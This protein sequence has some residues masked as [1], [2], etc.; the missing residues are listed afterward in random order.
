MSQYQDSPMGPAV[1]P[2]AGHS[3]AAPQEAP[4][5]P[6]L[7]VGI[8]A[9]AG[10]LAA[11]EQLF[12]ALP[13]DCGL[14]IVLAALPP[15][16]TPVQLVELLGRCTP[17]P[18]VLAEE[19]MRL[20]PDRVHVLAAGD[21]LVVNEDGFRVETGAPGGAGPHPLDHFFR[22][23]AREAGDRALA[24][25]LSG[26]GN[27]GAE[28]VKAVR[29]AGGTVLVQEPGSALNPALPR[30]AAAT[31][32][33]SLILPPEQLAG[34]LAE[35]A[36]QACPLP[37]KACRR[38]PFEEDLAAIFAIVKA[39]TG[40]DFSSYKRSTVIR[41]I[42]RRMAVNDVAGIKK[43][44]ILL[45]TSAQE[46]RALCQEILI[47]VTSFFRDPEAFEVLRRE[48]I[49]RLFANRDTEEP[50]RIWHACC[51]TGEEVYSTAI[52][53]CEFLKE[54]RL[55]ARVQFFA[56]DIDETS[57]AQARAGQYA[58]ESVQ[59]IGENRLREFFTRVDGRWQ[60]AKQ[61]REMIV[62]AH[63][64]LIKDPPFSR[65]DLLVCRN[66]LIYLN[67]EM[68]KRLT[69]LFHQVL[70]PKG[71][72]FLGAAETTGRTPQLF[73]PLDKKWKIFERLDGT[74]KEE[75]VFPFATPAR[76]FNRSGLAPRAAQ[77]GEPDPGRMAERLLIERY[78]PPCVVVNE[79]YELV[80]VS[81]RAGRLLEVPV[82]EPTRDLLQ[83]AREELR[84]AL[85]A[86]IYKAFSEK[87]QVAFRGVKIP[88]GTEQQAIN[89][90]VEP[91]KT[92][93]PAEPLVVVVFEPAP[94]PAEHSEGPGSAAQ[95]TER[96][97]SKDLLIRQLEEQLRIT[98]EQLVAVTEQLESSNE[99]FMS[100]N[101]E[102]M[103]INE[104]YQSANEEL[105]ST[106]EELET[107]KEELQALNEEMATVN[108]ELQGK[109]EELDRVN[110]DL[111]NLLAS[112]EIATIFLDPQLTIRRFSP[113]MAQLF[114]LIPAD[115]GRPFRHLVGAIDWGALPQDVDSVLE[116][117]EPVEREVA[118]PGE[119]RHYL[120]RVLPYR[121]SQGETE[122]V[123]VTLV[124]I[125]EH[126]RAEE[127]IYST[128]LFPEEN[129]Y[130]IL[131]VSRDGLLR[132]ANRAAGEL[133]GL[134]GCSV[135][136]QV[137]EPVRRELA[138][139]LESGTSRELEVRCKE[140]DL[141]FVLVPIGARDYVNLYG[142]DFTERNRA[143]E[144]LREREQRYRNLFHHNHAVMLLIDPQ[145]GAIIDANQAACSYYGYTLQQITAL[146]ITDINT[147]PPEQVR[148]QMEKAE[149]KQRRHF[150]FQHRLADGRIRDV[151]VFSGPIAIDGR[152]LLYS[153]VHDI[154]ERKQA[155]R[156]LQQ[157]HAELEDKVSERTAELREKDQLLLQQSRQ[158]AMGEMI[159]NIA[160]QWRQP[161]N[162]LGLIIQSLPM[163]SEAGQNSQDH[164]ESTTEKAMGI[165]LD[166]SQTID[167][168]RNYFKPEREK[169]AFHLSDPVSRTV[170]LVLES[171][172]DLK[173]AIEVETAQDPL[174]NGYP[175][176]FAQVLLNIL[177]NARDAIV[178]RRVDAAKISIKITSENGRASIRIADNA[179]G[180]PE[181]ILGKIFDP[182]FSTK[183]PDHGSGIG[184]FMSKNIIEKN[185]G[186][187]LLA[188][189]SGSGAEFTIEV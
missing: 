68:Q 31:G 115:V 145:G 106:N 157:A 70:K 34:K 167:D 166:M 153:I 24:V 85:R 28:G 39:R 75:V 174:V 102:L 14:T 18:I 7:I 61:L 80:H 43:Y 72:L 50:V 96:E 165:I 156:A 140:R 173:I 132:Y 110:S 33:A 152:E 17:M 161:L 111:E 5:K 6:C 29:E 71:L 189:N 30:S 188:R 32:E 92:T 60:V 147:L 125:S 8:A 15:S 150:F 13:A 183:S 181:D 74:R 4:R 76:R 178:E 179:G 22:A 63:H 103:S 38:A 114:N 171:F 82:G 107:S 108:A 55:A 93:P 98:H 187:R 119:R 58:D 186:G 130:P 40:H 101:E 48:I 117:L 172:K 158:A 100:A 42:E 149:A 26:I 180:I 113:A 126:K 11:L 104:E 87:Q 52:L 123:V 151:E 89:V 47:G 10:G 27:D 116:S 90:L 128:A 154:T 169:V 138:A 78:S 118:A 182:Y 139:A 54:Q 37:A 177:M 131:R 25:I 127:Q 41:R 16:P 112:S 91:L 88:L 49:P 143:E 66:F 65:L 137:P 141:S 3:P 23:L 59:S 142:R 176:E 105:Q 35:L 184:L 12:T 44:I 94:R 134:W 19:D 57:I 21:G 160:H 109:V 36:R 2:G 170:H 79:K 64:S 146:K 135:G 133:L 129:P 73:A 144:A 163:L 124:D 86:A 168:F 67:P 99:G 120:M 56:T 175:N 162:A 62:F 46:P 1:E 136:G 122:G 77:P 121:N 159:N 9:A 95:G 155:E 51:A 53:I 164:L 148:S 20:Q 83:M 81:S 185:M 45:E 69:T 84:P 97:H